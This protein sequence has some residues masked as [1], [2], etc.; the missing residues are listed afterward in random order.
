MVI[1]RCVFGAKANSYLEMVRTGA[2]Q[3]VATKP[4]LDLY[5]YVFI[6]VFWKVDFSRMVIF[7]R[8]EHWVPF[9]INTMY[10]IGV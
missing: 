7:C 3:F 8:T 4:R 6:Y 1:V 2:M 10:S 5:F 9:N